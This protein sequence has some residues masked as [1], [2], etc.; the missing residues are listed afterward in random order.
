MRKEKLAVEVI[1]DLSIIEKRYEGMPPGNASTA[2]VKKVVFFPVGFRTEGPPGSCKQRGSREAPAAIRQILEIQLAV[3][4]IP[5]RLQR[6][7]RVETFY[8]VIP[9][10]TVRRH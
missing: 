1:L 9:A 2:G 6:A 3:V 5:R 7:N 8:K 4:R 10:G